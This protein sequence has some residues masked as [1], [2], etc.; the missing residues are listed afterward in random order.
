MKSQFKTQKSYEQ[1]QEL[2]FRLIEKHEE[3][4]PIIADI[5]INTAEQKKYLNQFWVISK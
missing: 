1:R 5:H 3:M 2:S 4:I